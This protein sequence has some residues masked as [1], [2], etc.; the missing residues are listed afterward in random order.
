MGKWCIAVLLLSGLSVGCDREPLPV[1][2]LVEPLDPGEVFG[3]PSNSPGSSTN[4]PNSKP[5]S[6]QAASLGG[7]DGHLYHGTNMAA[8][9]GGAFAESSS[10]KTASA[11]A[12]GAG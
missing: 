9:P 6:S 11:V 4:D 7:V 12:T 3:E 8:L 5:Q 2:K 10:E 1:Q